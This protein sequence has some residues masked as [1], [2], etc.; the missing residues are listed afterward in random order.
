[1]VRTIRYL[2]TDGDII[3]AGNKMKKTKS[4][5]E[6]LFITAIALLVAL[7]CSINITGAW[8][9]SGDGLKVEC[10]VTIGKFN[11][12]LWQNE[13]NTGTRVYSSTENAT[14]YLDLSNAGANK[15]I[16][17]DTSYGLTLK[18]YNA[19]K[20]TSSFKLRYKINFIV[21]GKTSDTTLNNVTITGV[22]SSFTK[23]GDWYYYGSSST[24][25]NEFKYQTSATLITGF[26]IPY[27]EFYAK[28]LNGENLKVELIVD[29]TSNSTF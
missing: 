15:I 28:G 29:C 23:S 13:V 6:L 22:D 8:F 12:Q 25:L 14:S 18:L 16:L 21:C 10:T 7:L 17:P 20:G 26:S 9:S 2:M 11:L 4:R 27:S 19:D 1:M 3:R 24:S 5:I